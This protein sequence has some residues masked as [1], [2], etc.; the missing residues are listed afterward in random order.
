EWQ[1]DRLF[2]RRIADATYREVPLPERCHISGIAVCAS[3]PL[4][5]VHLIRIAHDGHGGSDAGI[6]RVPLPDG[7]PEPLP[8]PHGES[9]GWMSTLLGASADGS[10]VDVI[11]AGWANGDERGCSAGYQLASLDAATR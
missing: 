10:S 2:S 11:T 4:A 8:R 9:D 3:A 5:F 1:P 7:I 6:F